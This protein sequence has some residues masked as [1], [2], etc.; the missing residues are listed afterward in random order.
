MS[1]N[2]DSDDLEALFDSIVM[3]STPDAAPVESAKPEAKIESAPVAQ[4]ATAECYNE[5]VYSQI[6]HMTRNLHDTLREL[7]YDKS[8]ETAVHSM[9]DTKDR[10]NYIAALTQQAAERALNATEVA[11]PIQDRLEADAAALS[12]NWLRLFDKQMDVNEFKTLV[13]NT[14]GF[15]SDIPART[16]ATNDQLTEI[17]MAQDFQDLT[18]QVIKK[19]ID[20]AQ[21]VEQQLVKLL[22]ESTPPEKMHDINPSLLNGPVINAAGRNDVVTSQAQVDELLDSLGF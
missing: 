21:Q 11:R 19:V 5:A 6:G 14:R 3:A 4:T 10:L 17:M 8:L 16:K 22:V 2:D 1:N 7:G 18:G 13:T 9:P 20:I 15:L 12:Q